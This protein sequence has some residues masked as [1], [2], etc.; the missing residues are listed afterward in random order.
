MVDGASLLAQMV[1]GLLAQRFWRDERGV[2]LLDGHA[3]FYDT[4]TCADGRHVAVGALE[5]QFYAA[6]LAGLGIPADE[7]PE[8]YDRAGWAVL[9]ARFTEAFAART[10]DEWAEVFSGS[11]AF[12]PPVLAFG[13]GPEHPTMAAYVMN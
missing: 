7:L 13:A 4:Y 8:Q 3:P 1:W 12:V 6:L 11:D 9:R 5:P 10:R 2:N